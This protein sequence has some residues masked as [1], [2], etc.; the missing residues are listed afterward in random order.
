MLSP[1]LV[2]GPTEGPV[3]LSEA[4]EHLRVD[5]SHEDALI[6]AMLDAAVSHIDGIN[7]TLGRALMA[8]T[9]S[10]EY[11]GFSGDMVL[12]FGPVQSVNSVSYD[13][14]TFEDYR[15]L[16]DGRGPFLR[17]N[18]GSSWPS[19]SEPVTI[20]FVAGFADFPASIRAAI[21]LHVGTLY[22]HRTTM[23][24]GVKPSTAYD[25]LLSPYRVWR[26]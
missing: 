11:A 22:E 19:T 21:L 10:Q 7:G 1:V 2:S 8:Q 4:K 15:L 14:Q 13:G 20:E 6:Q 17:V 5:H 18:S 26:G 9:W 3:P 12:P 24:D 23:L 16:N 25:A